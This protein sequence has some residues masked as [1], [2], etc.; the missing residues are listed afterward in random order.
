MAFLTITMKYG[1]PD[2]AGIKH[3]AP[4]SVVL[5]VGAR[6]KNYRDVAMDMR[7]AAAGFLQAEKAFRRLRGHKSISALVHAL[8]PTILQHPKVA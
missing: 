1:K 2:P 7:W 5:N 3:R 8:R 4:N 6:V